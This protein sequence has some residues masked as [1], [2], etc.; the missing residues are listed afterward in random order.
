[1]SNQYTS[2]LVDVNCFRQYVVDL[3][4]G[5][6]QRKLLLQTH[7]SCTVSV[8]SDQKRH[9]HVCKVCKLKGQIF[10]SVCF[11]RNSTGISILLHTHEALLFTRIFLFFIFILPYLFLLFCFSTRYWS[12]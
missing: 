10:D 11:T 5:V 8:V 12:L 1:M 4:S 7:V 9:C 3:R 6:L 2:S